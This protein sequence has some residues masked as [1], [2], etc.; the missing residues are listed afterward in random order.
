MFPWG[1]YFSFSRLEPRSD[2]HVMHSHVVISQKY[3]KKYPPEP[4][5]SQQTVVVH[6]NGKPNQFMGQSPNN[7]MTAW[8]RRFAERQQRV[9]D[10]N[11]RVA[12]ESEY[13]KT[14]H[15]LPEIPTALQVTMAEVN[16]VF[17]MDGFNQ[18]DDRHRS[19]ANGYD[20]DQAI[21]VVVRPIL[22]D[23]MGINAVD[24]NTLFNISKS[25]T[26]RGRHV[27]AEDGW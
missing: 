16:L 10:D 22:G 12:H 20:Y 8:M 17:A 9:R 21:D 15:V 4:I 24:Q 5:L 26:G 7:E 27:G 13:R 2:T 23:K 3:L 19:R 25:L 6:G 11:A 1:A 18:M 14:R